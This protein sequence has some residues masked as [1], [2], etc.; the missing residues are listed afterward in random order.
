MAWHPVPASPSTI[1]T[2]YSGVRLRVHVPTG[3]KQLDKRALRAYNNNNDDN[4][5]NTIWT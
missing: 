2:G 3:G 1:Q 4:N 5:N